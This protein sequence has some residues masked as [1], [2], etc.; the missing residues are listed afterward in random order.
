MGEFNWGTDQ[1]GSGLKSPGPFGA[2]NPQEVRSGDIEMNPN[3]R[4][5]NRDE[6]IGWQN[7]ENR[8]TN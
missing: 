5:K 1:E 2:Y 4:V 8:S 3:N 6:G 7:K